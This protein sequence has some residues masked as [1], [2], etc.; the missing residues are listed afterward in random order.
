MGREKQG[1]SSGQLSR[2]PRAYYKEI[3]MGRGH[4]VSYLVSLLVA[5]PYTWKYGYPRWIIFEIHALAIK[6]LRSGTYTAQ[7]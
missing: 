4:L 6:S 7:T 5:L 3:F 2:L 1:H